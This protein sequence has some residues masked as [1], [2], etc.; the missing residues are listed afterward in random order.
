MAS[1]SLLLLSLG[2]ITVNLISLPPLPST[3]VSFPLTL[4]C[5]A[6][7]RVLPSSNLLAYLD[8]TASQGCSQGDFQK[9]LSLL[10]PN[11][12]VDSLPWV[13]GQH[14][15]FTGPFL[16]PAPILPSR[17][18]FWDDSSPC[19]TLLHPSRFLDCPLSSVL[20]LCTCCSLWEW[21]FP[22]RTNLSPNC[23]FP[24]RFP[25]GPIDGLQV[26]ALNL[27]RGCCL[28]H[29]TKG[30]LE[31]GDQCVCPPARETCT[32]SGVQNAHHDELLDHSEFCERCW[33]DAN[34]CARLR[35]GNSILLPTSSGHV[36]SC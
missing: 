33:L 3:L 35:R 23:G 1:M 2:S 24:D 14:I 8:P 34:T 12:F 27:P 25:L 29:H 15:T 28:S 36:G 9:S 32:V 19:H 13:R 7:S 30:F 20:C 5:S 4:Q 22:H 10:N 26:V 31:T 16:L 11:P 17:L 21:C 6:N 18:P